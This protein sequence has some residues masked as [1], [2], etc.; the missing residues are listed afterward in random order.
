MGPIINFF[1]SYQ[2]INLKLYTLSGHIYK[3]KNDFLGILN[4]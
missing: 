4:N 1:Y 2:K 3:Q